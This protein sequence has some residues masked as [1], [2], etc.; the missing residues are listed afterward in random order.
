MYKL[1]LYVFSVILDRKYSQTLKG[2]SVMDAA[3]D[4]ARNK[5]VPYKVCFSTSPI[6]K[7]SSSLWAIT[8]FY[9]CYAQTHS[10]VVKSKPQ[11]SFSS[12][13]HPPLSLAFTSHAFSQSF[14][15]F[16]SFRSLFVSSRWLPKERKKVTCWFSPDQETSF[17]P[18]QLPAHAWR[19]SCW[20][21]PSAGSEAGS[22]QLS[23]P[24]SGW[25][26]TQLDQRSLQMQTANQS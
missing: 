15:S 18:N 13:L 16:Y 11:T 8:V 23:L 7:Q 26:A 19:P 5:T 12:H 9:F 21:S 17:C 2:N 14:R 20:C 24:C 1:L 25:E 4:Q 6:Q 10:L 22:P 3:W